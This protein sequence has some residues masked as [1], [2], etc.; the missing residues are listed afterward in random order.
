MNCLQD[1]KKQLLNTLRNLSLATSADH[2]VSP[3]R[4]AVLKRCRT[5]FDHSGMYFGCVEMIPGFT[6]RSGSY[7]WRVD[8]SSATT[9]EL[10]VT[11]VEY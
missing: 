5:T 4:A 8:P 10:V 6:A 1:P 2:P 7:F 3:E 9:I 11:V